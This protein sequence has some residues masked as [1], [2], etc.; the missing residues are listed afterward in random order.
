VRHDGSTFF[1]QVYPTSSIVKALESRRDSIDIVEV[2]DS[3]E[4]TARMLAE[5][6]TIG[7]FQGG[8][9]FGPRALGHRSIL[10][11]PRKPEMRDF[12]NSK[13]KF[14]EDFRPFAPSVPLE[15][16]GIYF[17]C[18]Y[19]SP[20]MILVAPV[21]P[22]WIDVIPSVIH[23][24]QSCRIQTVTEASDPKY[25]RLLHAFKRATGV[26]VLLNTSF[27]RRG[28]PIVEMPAQALDFFLRCALDVLV[29]NNHIV[30]KKPS[31]PNRHSQ[32]QL[33]PY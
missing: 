2:G 29:L 5:G 13:I 30:T 4:E 28:M 26:S 27:N 7:W 12:I 8:S 25:Y 19:E 1:G 11:D 32:T 22:E 20:Y 23:R 18:Q 16:V 6:K 21:R 33:R 15:D 9:E 31:P 14:R 10:A 24:D 17:D 3:I